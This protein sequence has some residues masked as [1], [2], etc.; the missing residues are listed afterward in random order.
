MPILQHRP[1]QRSKAL[2][3]HVSKLFDLTNFIVCQ[4]LSRKCDLPIEF[5]ADF[6]IVLGRDEV[7]KAR[8]DTIALDNPGVTLNL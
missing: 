4:N 1:A 8:V 7:M 3:A 2:A 5:L 6:C